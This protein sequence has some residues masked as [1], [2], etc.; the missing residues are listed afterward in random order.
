M[1]ST[2]GPLRVPILTDLDLLLRERGQVVDDPARS[3]GVRALIRLALLLAAV[4]GASLGSFGVIQGHDLSTLQFLSAS[5]KLPLLFALTL[6]VT[7]PSLYVFATLLRLQLGAGATLR[8]LLGAIAVQLAVMASLGPVFVF[9]AASTDSYPFL[10]VLNVAIAGAGGVLSLLILKRSADRVLKVGHAGHRLLMAWCL[11]YGAVGAQMAWL[12]RP[13]LGR[14]GSEFQW[15]RPT[16]SSFFEAVF[17]QLG[18]WIT[19]S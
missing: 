7:F 12:L 8:S 4:Y 1:T 10:F 14:P 3:L 15:L 2:P 9:F 11:V 16:E 5:I 18:A 6:V 13:F 17:H 19:G